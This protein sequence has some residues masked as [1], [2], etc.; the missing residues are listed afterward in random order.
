MRAVIAEFVAT[1]LLL[2]IVVG[3][4]ILGERL[5][6][7]NVALA[8]LANSLATGAGLVAL[9]LA[10]GPVSGAHMNPAV[11]L[12]AAA[13]GEI[14]WPRVGGYVAAQGL[15]ALAGVA[16]AHAMF[17][18]PLWTAGTQPRH[19]FPLWLGEVVA[20]F[21]LVVVVFACGR[22]RPAA[23]PFAV[24]A[25][26]TA[27]YWFTSSTSFANPAVTLARAS[28]T[29]FT[30]I[31]PGDVVPFVLAQLVGAAAGAAMYYFVL[32]TPE[33]R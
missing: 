19:G 16:L 23:T 4:G 3:S 24:G 14:R 5:A 25:I 32:R 15:G 6:G 10:F 7:G 27:G 13:V 1:A 8:L 28:T 29:T 9:C 30:G 31:A 17:D 18:L 26:I 20:T 11:T 33:A 12:V 22:S 2:A 21:A